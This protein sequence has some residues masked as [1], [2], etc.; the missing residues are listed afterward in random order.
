MKDCKDCLHA[1]RGKCPLHA[2]PTPDPKWGKPVIEEILR[3]YRLHTEL[4]KIRLRRL[5]MPIE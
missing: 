5:G 1:P 2:N 4:Q 3:E